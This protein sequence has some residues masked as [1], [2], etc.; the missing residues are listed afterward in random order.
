[1]DVRT[2]LEKL[3][4][5]LYAMSLD[6]SIVPKCEIEML[7]KDIIANAEG[8]AGRGI[9]GA[10]EALISQGINNAECNDGKDAKGLNVEFGTTTPTIASQHNVGK[11]A[12]VN[13]GEIDIS[14]IINEIIHTLGR[15]LS[16]LDNAIDKLDAMCEAVERQSKDA[17]GASEMTATLG[18]TPLALDVKD[19]VSEQT[20]QFNL[21]AVVTILK[22][23]LKEITEAFLSIGSEMDITLTARTLKTFDVAQETTH[24]LKVI[25][26]KVNGKRAIPNIEQA[27]EPNV[28][29]QKYKWAKMGDLKNKLLDEFFNRK[30]IERACMII[31]Q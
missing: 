5:I 1:M 22:L 26:E 24:E 11:D 13:F 14:P 27:V 18:I 28:S 16:K 6:Y 20:S 8:H 25:S 12:D 23:T 2:Y 17:C 9:S 31:A 21:N 10:I 30:A 7:I 29:A 3:K 4:P 19:A 15:E